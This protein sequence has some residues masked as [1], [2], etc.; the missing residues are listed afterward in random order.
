MDVIGGLVFRSFPYMSMSSY[1]HGGDVPVD[2]QQRT[3]HLDFHGCAA[4]G[5]CMGKEYTVIYIITQ[6]S[7]IPFIPPLL[8]L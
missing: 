5:A 4:G 7:C 1:L 3:M 2:C 6:Q 8:P